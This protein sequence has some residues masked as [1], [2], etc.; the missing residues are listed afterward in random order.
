MQFSKVISKN[1][2]LSWHSQIIIT[3]HP[4]SFSIRSECLSLVL[5]VSILESHHSGLVF[6]KTKYLHAVCPCQKQPFINM[7]VLYLRS[8][9]SGLP[10][11]L[12]SCSLYRYPRANR[13]FLTNI[14]GLVSLLRIRD[15]L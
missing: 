15:M 12:F 3:F 8:T 1:P 4:N 5:F 13:N 9:R 11:K 2:F 10:G 6:G 14:S 7:T